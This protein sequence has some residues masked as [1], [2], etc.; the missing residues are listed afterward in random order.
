MC[1]AP[2]PRPPPAPTP[3]RLSRLSAPRI[4]YDWSLQDSRIQMC[5][6]DTYDGIL[7]GSRRRNGCKL[8]DATSAGL[9][10]WGSPRRN[11]MRIKSTHNDELLLVSKPQVLTQVLFATRRHSLLL[12]ANHDSLE[13]KPSPVLPLQLR[14]VRL[15]PGGGNKSRGFCASSH[16][17][18]AL[19]CSDLLSV[20]PGRHL[21]R[22]A[23]AALSP[24]LCHAV[25]SRPFAPALLWLERKI[26][27]LR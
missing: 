4:A 10:N 13:G 8:R 25:H 19:F 12:R 22:T 17:V 20:D 15:A 27:S 23:V 2:P 11:A 1:Y 14:L 26:T 7:V 5:L 18:Q 3:H 24:S 21:L 6:H 9:S 16:S